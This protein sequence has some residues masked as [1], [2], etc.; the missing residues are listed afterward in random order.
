MY[1]WQLLNLNL[2]TELD[3]HKMYS[4]DRNFSSVIDFLDRKLRKT[5]VQLVE[6]PCYFYLG[7]E[8]KLEVTVFSNPRIATVD[9]RMMKLKN[10]DRDPYFE[11]SYDLNGLSIT[12][13]QKDID[14]LISEIS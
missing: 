14:N 10:Y 8:A 6:A 4:I 1:F 13:F 3:K 12:T 5:S 2:Y 9:V 7:N 11:R